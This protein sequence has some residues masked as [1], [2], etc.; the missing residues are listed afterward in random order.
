MRQFQIVKKKKWAEGILNRKYSGRELYT[1][2]P[3][4][5]FRFL[6]EINEDGENQ[7]TKAFYSA[8][9]VIYQKIISLRKLFDSYLMVA[10]S[11]LM[12]L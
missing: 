11:I 8:S 4:V 3:L 6:T 9:V 7:F 2:P 5:S 12:Q 10:C 1:E